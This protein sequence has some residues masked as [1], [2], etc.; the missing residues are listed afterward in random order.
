MEDSPVPGSP[1]A[2]RSE[3]TAVHE[4]ATGSPTRRE[5]VPEAL[6]EAV[7]KRGPEPVALAALRP[8]D[9]PR[10]TGLRA[11]HLRA[12]M[13]AA[14]GALPPIVV[15]AP[16]MRVIDGMHR[17]EAARRRGADTVEAVLFDGDESA[18]LVAALRLNAAGGLPLS[19]A[20]R[21]RAAA[22]L[23]DAQPAWPDR[24]VASMTG[25]PPATVA[26][27]RR[28]R[29]RPAR[30]VPGSGVGPDGRIRPVSGEDRRRM[31]GEMLALNPKLS[32]RQVARAVGVPPET[33]RAIRQ[34]MQERKQPRRS[35]NTGSDAS[36][37]VK[38]PVRA[39]TA[40]RR[41]KGQEPSPPPDQYAD[42]IERLKADPSLRSSD[43][44]RSLLRLLTLH[45][46]LH[47]EDWDRIAAQVPA[48]RLTDVAE[49]AAACARVWSDIAARLTERAEQ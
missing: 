46:A 7:L 27:L 37:R 17:L 4:P 15:H 3:M 2:F 12:L 1:T 43:A 49:L 14:D 24:A 40:T 48:H 11:K 29:P 31:A 42:L 28:P 38:K 9:G 16:T 18:A 44:G 39:A 8:S 13:A 33:V 21:K 47:A 20:D 45:S 34:S 36:G 19:L 23:L 41:A 25:L 10:T 35:Q 22:R 26:A 32:P 30:A 5:P 6:P